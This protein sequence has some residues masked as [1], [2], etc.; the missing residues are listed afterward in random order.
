MVVAH[1]WLKLRYQLLKSNQVGPLAPKPNVSK[2]G[3]VDENVGRAGRVSAIFQVKSSAVKQ[4]GGAI[5]VKEHGRE[6]VVVTLSD[7]RALRRTLQRFRQGARRQV[8]SNTTIAKRAAWK[9]TTIM[10]A[11]A[12]KAR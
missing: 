3:V 6:R 2:A 9:N 11:A 7:Q 12:R 5:G 10:R 4:Q 1:Q 8:G